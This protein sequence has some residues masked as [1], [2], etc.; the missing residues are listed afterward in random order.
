M[1]ISRNLKSHKKVINIKFEMPN[2]N[3]QSHLVLKALNRIGILMGKKIE[4]EER[5]EKLRKVLEKRRAKATE[6][7]KDIPKNAEN[8]NEASENSKK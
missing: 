4:D 2:R 7:P 1:K 3:Q 8:G 5:R 6:D